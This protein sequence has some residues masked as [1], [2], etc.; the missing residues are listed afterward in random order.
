[1]LWMSPLEFQPDAWV[2]S[3]QGDMTGHV[4]TLLPHSSLVILAALGTHI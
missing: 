1:M 3:G 2:G 4:V